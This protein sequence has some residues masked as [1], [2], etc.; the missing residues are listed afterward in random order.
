MTASAMSNARATIVEE[1]AERREKRIKVIEKHRKTLDASIVGKHKG[2]RFRKFF[3]YF[4]TT[5]AYKVFES[6]E[7]EYQ[8]IGKVGYRKWTFGLQESYR[9]NE[10]MC[11]EGV[12]ADI[13][14]EFGCYDY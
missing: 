4:V 5:V 12:I 2:I 14:N 13:I 9:D 11:K 6:E 10:P 1:L 3:H 7:E 8:C